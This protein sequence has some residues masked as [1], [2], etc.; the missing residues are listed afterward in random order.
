MT[1]EE[2]QEVFRALRVLKEDYLMT[3]TVV[4]KKIKN[5]NGVVATTCWDMGCIFLISSLAVIKQ[6]KANIMPLTQD[7]TIIEAWRS[8]S[9]E[10]WKGVNKFWCHSS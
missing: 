6:L 4:Y 2:L 5:D 10:G 1:T 3:D 8:Q 9:L 7:L